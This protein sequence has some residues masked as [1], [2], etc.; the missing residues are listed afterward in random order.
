MHDITFEKLPT[1]DDHFRRRRR[2][3]RHNHHHHHDHQP[4]RSTLLVVAIY[5]L[6][7]EYSQ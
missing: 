4:Y 7:I 5:N 3:R 1:L 6:N 2:R